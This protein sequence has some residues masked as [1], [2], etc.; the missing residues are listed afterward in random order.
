MF[1]DNGGDLTIGAQELK[2]FADAESSPSEPSSYISSDLDS[3]LANLHLQDDFSSFAIHASATVQNG[4]GAFATRDI[5]RGD[6]V[7]SE[8]PI[9]CIIT[10]A[11]EP[12]RRIYIEAAV[13]D[14]S[15]A[16]LDSYLSLQNSH[17]KCSCFPNPL[18]GIYGTNSFNVADDDSGICLRASRFNHSC[19]PNARYSFNSNT[20]ELRIYALGTIPRGEEIFI[21]Y[22]SNRRLYGSP[23]RSRQTTLRNWYHFTCACSVCSLPEAESKMSDTRR[24]KVKKLLEFTESYTPTQGV[25]CLH[26]IVEAILLLREEG[27]LADVDDFTNVAGPICAFHCDF[28][29]AGYWAGLTYHTRVAEFGD[30]SSEAAEVRDLSLNPQSFAFAGWGP[31]M[32]FSGIRV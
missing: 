29:S 13:R 20:G 11:P 1:I 31:P 22:I 30:D 18:L 5:Q 28:V 16:N 17:N 15:P 25:Q 19:S 7:L 27:Y 9:F 2:A 10:N 12:L 14:L 23:R 8:R 4:K 3:G 24:Q 26:V 6:L 21:A 32:D